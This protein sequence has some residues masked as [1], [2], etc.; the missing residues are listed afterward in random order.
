MSSSLTIRGL[1]RRDRV[2]RLIG[3]SW[4]ALTGGPGRGRDEER[5]TLVACSGGADSSALV[6]ALE[7]AVGVKEG[8]AG[9]P[10]GARV[11]AGR[12]V[13]GH[14]VHD[15]R[16]RAEAEADRDAA[17]ALAG[18]LGLGFVESRVE[19]KGRRGN[20]EAVARRERYAALTL[21]AAEQGCGFVATAHH[22]DDQLETLLMG[23]VRGG[24]P[25]ALAG[26]A[27]SRAMGRVRIIRPALGVT[28]AELRAAC[29]RAGWNWREDATNADETRL[30]SALRHRVLP[31]LEEIRPGA[32][33][34]AAHAAVLQAHAARMVR[35]LAEEVV[36]RGLVEA[37][38]LWEADQLRAMSPMVL[39]EALRMAALGLRGGCGA[40]RI[41]SRQIGPVVEAIAARRTGSWD[42]P[43]VR[44]EVDRREVRLCVR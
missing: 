30:R 40:D 10:T 23:V 5:R 7:A 13:V 12:L 4:R 33:R 1:T 3:P 35:E 26:I 15:L 27:A 42:W 16:S 38:V 9:G 6:L 2:V 18:S 21:M 44:V 36:E 19:V 37:G 32:A 31:I 24:G 43:G 20:A 29:G 14:V 25:R 28:R 17:R 39:G 8:G 34:R 41:G 11:G 22:A